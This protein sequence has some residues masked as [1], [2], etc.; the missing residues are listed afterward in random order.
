MRSDATV[1]CAEGH[2]WGLQPAK[3]EIDEPWCPVCEEDAN[4]D[5]SERREKAIEMAR[6]MG[7]ANAED[8]VDLIQRTND[9]EFDNERVTRD[10]VT[11]RRFTGLELMDQLE[12]EGKPRLGDEFS[13]RRGYSEAQIAELHEFYRLLSKIAETVD[14]DD[15]CFLDGFARGQ[16]DL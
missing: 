2:R 1:E 13:R 4:K 5:R 12:S 3:I 7:I 16:L 10:P 14:E 6:D 15:L 9:A 11:G 8:F